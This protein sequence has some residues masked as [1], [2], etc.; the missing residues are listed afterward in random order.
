MT[1]DTRIRA[2]QIHNLAVLVTRICRQHELDAS[3]RAGRMMIRLY[4]N[5]EGIRGD[6]LDDLLVEAC[7]RVAA[8]ARLSRVADAAATVALFVGGACA[9]ILASLTEAGAAEA[10]A[11]LVATEAGV[12]GTFVAG[13]IIGFAAGAGATY[14]VFPKGGATPPRTDTLRDPEVW[15]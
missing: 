9:W 14:V 13:L 12:I 2:V 10:A 8:R 5:D 15:G 4:L 7:E 1:T 6:M 3:D 11:P